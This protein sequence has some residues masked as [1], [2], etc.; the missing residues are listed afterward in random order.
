MF[1]QEMAHKKKNL[2]YVFSREAKNNP[3][4]VKVQ[5]KKK[6]RVS[7]RVLISLTLTLREW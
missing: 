3:E 2:V 7:S 1:F 4:V 5:K 6:K